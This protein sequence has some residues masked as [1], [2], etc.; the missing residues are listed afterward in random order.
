VIAGRTKAD[1]QQSGD[2]TPDLG[3]LVREAEQR[4]AGIA[5]RTPMV[6]IGDVRGARVRLKLEN[7][8]LSGSFKARGAANKL[9]SDPARRRVVA[10]SGGNH[11]IAVAAAAARMGMSADL[12]VPAAAP[13]LKMRLIE[14]AGGSVVPVEGSFAEAEA[15]ATLNARETDSLFVHPFDDSMVVAGQGTVGLEILDAWPSVDTIVV[16]VGGGGLAAGIVAAVG[17]RARCV[18]VEP[19]LCPTLAEACAAGRPVVVPVAGTAVDSLGA[20]QLGSIA[21]QTLSR[22]EGDPV[23]VAETAIVEARKQLWREFRLL[24]EPG[25]A[26][27]WAAL[28]VLEDDEIRGRNVAVVVCGGNTE[29]TELWD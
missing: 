9:A 20:P 12:F 3:Q 19:E 14:E 5:R 18:T 24:V 6:D 1:A 27:A 22:L 4:I 29:P 11:G 17:E 10:A 23:L 28:G 13:P 7:L 26:C 25:A 21:W 16:A 15:R 8:Q 2:E